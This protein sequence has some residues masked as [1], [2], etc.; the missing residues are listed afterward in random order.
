VNNRRVLIISYL[1]PPIGGIGVQRPLKF[2]RYLREYGWEPVVLTTDEAYSVQ[3]DPSLL[4]EIPAGVKVVRCED[5]LSRATRKLVSSTT[6][7]A[8]SKTSGASTTSSAVSEI[9]SEA[10]QGG[11]ET[12]VPSV[13]SGGW[14]KRLKQVLSHLKNALL[15][16]DESVLWALR[17]TRHGKQLVDE[18][19]FAGTQ[20]IDCIYTTSGPHSTHLVGWLLKRGTRV[21]WVAD[22]RDPWTQNMHFNHSGV[23]KAVE[24]WM[25][26]RVFADADAVI[27]VT[28]GFADLFRRKYPKYA[29]KLQV[30][31]NGVDPD[32][33]PRIAQPKRTERFTL[34]YG[35]ILY[36][37]R[38]PAALFQALNTAI[39]YGKLSP[40]QIRVQ[41]AG[42]FDYPGHTENRN[43]CRELGLESVVEVLGYLPHR[44]VL[45]RIQEVDALLLIGERTGQENP[46]VAGKLY[47]YLHVQKPILALLE[48]GEAA[49][50]IR[51][52]RAGDVVDPSDVAGIMQA[53]LGFVDAHAKKQRHVQA[54]PQGDIVRSNQ[55]TRQTQTAELARL[56]NQLVSSP[57]PNSSRHLNENATWI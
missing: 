16:P 19:R 40:D 27:T 12:S 55:Y 47:E 32:D 17:A 33:F 23:R 44:D 26:R 11:R 15:V 21:K 8:V 43:L 30:I 36:P 10:A 51:A 39:R 38:S 41:F 42:V 48:D 29:H 14:R 9:S 13:T 4:A 22:F 18:S 25:E 5:P 45:Q 56:M 2:T 35:G 50:L 57:R 53:L 6:S 49:R 7:S 52:D 34:F 46:Y 31:R 3:N 28:A 37:K 20:P 1:F 24:E 54:E